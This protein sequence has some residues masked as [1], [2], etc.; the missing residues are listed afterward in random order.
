M[1]R[2]PRVLKRN[3]RYGYVSIGRYVYRVPVRVLKA[4]EAYL[5]NNMVDEI[6]ETMR[7]IQVHEKCPLVCELD[8]T[9][10]Y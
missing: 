8:H 2:E 5:D 1:A 6:D 9:L 4:L 10:E 3:A 7:L